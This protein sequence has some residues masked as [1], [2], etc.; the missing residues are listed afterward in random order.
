MRSKLGANINKIEY[1]EK[2][3]SRGPIDL[4]NGFY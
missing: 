2:Y 1:F 4:R 3:D